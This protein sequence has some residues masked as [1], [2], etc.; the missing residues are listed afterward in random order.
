MR[1]GVQGQRH[2]VCD[3][4]IGWDTKTSVRTSYWLKSRLRMFETQG[5]SMSTAKTVVMSDLHISNAAAYSWFKGNCV[6]NA[7]TMFT[8]LASATDV[9]ELV[10][11]GDTFDSWLLEDPRTHSQRNRR[12]DAGAVGLLAGQ[13]DNYR[14][15]DARQGR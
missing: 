14:A 4:A 5:G 1:V 12:D 9:D 3:D 15:A 13:G 8:R 10:L 2:C 7:V 6:Q 11:L